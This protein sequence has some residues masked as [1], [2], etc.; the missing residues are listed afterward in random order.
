M[1]ALIVDASVPPTLALERIRGMVSSRAMIDNPRFRRRQIL[2]WRF[3]ELRSGFSLQPE[4]GDAASDFGA[5]FEGRIEERETGS[6]VVGRV[7]LSRLMLA[8][9]SVIVV[10]VVVA[11]GASV[12]EGREPVLRVVSIGGLM[13]AGA[14]LLVR[15]SLRSTATLVEIGLRGALGSAD[16]SS[17]RSSG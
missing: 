7:I 15:Y 10:F 14:V 8:I 5:R 17:L 11:M 13:I 6:R 9:M 4:Y 16:P 1:T 2:G 3:R 12:R